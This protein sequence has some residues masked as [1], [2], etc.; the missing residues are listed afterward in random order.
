[1][2]F[3]GLYSR[4][5]DTGAA[6]R[7]APGAAGLRALFLG[8]EPVV[9]V[10]AVAAYA[11]WCLGVPGGRSAIGSDRGPRLVLLGLAAGCW[12]GLVQCVRGAA[13]WCDLA[14]GALGL[15]AG[16]HWGCSVSLL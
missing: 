7:T 12:P 6:A 1:M 3:G 16:G 14:L 4:G 8:S 11:Y 15:A 10:A 13:D 2:H 5:L 9:F